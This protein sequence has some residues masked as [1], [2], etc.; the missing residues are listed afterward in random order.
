M[1]IRMSR[2]WWTGDICKFEFELLLLFISLHSIFLIIAC[3]SFKNSKGFNFRI[4]FVFVFQ[5]LLHFIWISLSLQSLT[6]P[7]GINFYNVA[8]KFN[9][10]LGNLWELIYFLLLEIGQ[11]RF[12]F[13]NYLCLNFRNRSFLNYWRCWCLVWWQRTLSFNPEQMLK[14]FDKHLP[15]FL[16]N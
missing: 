12:L 10:G 13:E 6:K 8:R 15:F 2:K 4:I 3:T 14:R 9:R 11:K 5:F 7:M 16:N 1:M